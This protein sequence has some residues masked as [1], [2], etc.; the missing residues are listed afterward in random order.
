M[1][2]QVFKPYHQ[3][4]I[5]LLPPS[6]EELIPEGH[7][8][9]VLDST[10]DKIDC[11]MMIE[12]YQGGGTSAYHP[13]MMLKVLLYAYLSKIYTSRKIAK[14]LREDINFMWLSGGNRPDFRTINNFRSGKLKTLIDGIFGS[15]LEL[16]I[17]EG[18][19]RLEHYFI[20]GTKMRSNAGKNTYVWK[21][22]TQRY[23]KNT[24]DRIKTLIEQID[25][26]N[27]NENAEYG[28]RDL[29]ELGEGKNI[30]SEE[31]KKKIERLKEKI[32]DENKESKKLIKNL[33]KESS[34]LEKYERQEEIL[35]KRGSYSK[36]D[37]DS[38]FYRFKDKRLLP[39]Y[40]LILGTEDQFILNYSL[41]QNPSE[42]VCFIPH[43]KKLKNLINRYPS[44]VVGDS[45]YGSQ[46]NY[47]FIDNNDIGNYLKYPTFH[48]EQTKKFKKENFGYD[49]ETD[50]YICPANRRLKLKKI[51]MKKTDNDYRKFVKVYQCK[52]CRGCEYSH[53]CKQKKSNRIIHINPV[54]E[55]YKYEARENLNSIT[56]I[57]LRKQRNIDVESSI[58]DIKWNQGYIRFLLRGLEK[59]NVETGLLS[60]SHNI[61]KI[62][63]IKLENL[64]TKA[65]NLDFSNIFP[66]TIFYNGYNTKLVS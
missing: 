2:D 54:L 64:K 34:N 12:S 58:G 37:N 10:V 60:I 13:V 16:L 61:K 31:L 3:H 38:T 49:F 17:A 28:E 29:E 22:N 41:H 24:E 35:G 59:N 63:T 56:G 8:V 50:E 57:Q 44:N 9:R 36:T 7:L 27:D 42:T 21:K 23:K 4:Q 43:M 32:N 11:T 5:M 40:N 25:R 46:E 19:V 65:Q 52:N 6:L 1:P 20:D 51:E 15:L 45:T 14:A 53:K 47:E 55:K 48:R 18:Y 26:L 62:F 33:E 30:K 39:G 66:K